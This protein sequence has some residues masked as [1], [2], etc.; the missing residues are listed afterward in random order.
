MNITEIINR[1]QEIKNMH[2]ELPLF[3]FNKGYVRPITHPEIICIAK[4]NSTKVED[5][6]YFRVPAEDEPF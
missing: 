5:R 3:F 2:G 4:G 6:V 1:L